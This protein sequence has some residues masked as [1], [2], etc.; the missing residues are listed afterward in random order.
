MSPSATSASIQSKMHKLSRENPRPS[1][2]YMEVKG[3][4]R[5]AT[6]EGGVKYSCRA[7]RR[8]IT[9]FRK[10]LCVLKLSRRRSQ[11][12]TGSAAQGSQYTTLKEATEHSRCITAVRFVTE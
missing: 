2:L 9:G 7:R 3:S 6:E 11:E 1:G 4:R 8:T 10:L 5:N 12:N